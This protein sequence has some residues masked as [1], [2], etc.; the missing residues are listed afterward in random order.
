MPIHRLISS[1][2]TISGI[3][4][5]PTKLAR[6][7]LL[8]ICAVIFFTAVGVRLL[9]WQDNYAELSRGRTDSG[10]QLVAFFYYDQARRIL[11]DGG[12]LFPRNPV[13][14][15]DATVLTHPPGYS[16]LMAAVFKT[17]YERGAEQRLSAADAGLRVIQII[18]DAA[19]TVVTF[20]IAAELFPVAVAIIAAMLCA[21]SPHFAYYSLML[22]PDS[23]SVLPI[24]LAVYFVI[25]ALKRPR[26]ITVITVGALIGLSCWLRSNALLLAPFLALIIQLLFERGKRLRYSLAVMAGAA[27][28]IVPI[29]IRNW[30]VFHQFVPLSVAAG[31]NLVQGIA[32]YDKENSFGMP[33]TDAEAAL[34]DAEWYGRPDYAESLWRPDGIE[35]DKA[36]FGRGL[37]V[38][39]S[40]PGWFLGVMLRRMEFMLRYNDFRQQYLP[41][42]S[43]APTLLAAPN[44][45]HK[46]EPTAQMTAMWSSSSSELMANGDLLSMPAQATILDDNQDLQITGDESRHRDT[47]SYEPIEVKKNADYLL[48]L[49]VYLERGNADLKIGTAN[50]RIV[51]ALVAA[52]SAAREPKRKDTSQPGSTRKP[53]MK[54]LL[55][56]FASGDNTQIRLSLQ[57]STGEQTM[58][59]VGQAEMYEIGPTGYLWTRYPR[60]AIRGVQKNI[61]KTDLMRALIIVGIILLALARQGRALAVLLIVPVYYLLA[62]SPLGT[63]YRYVLAIH[64]FLFVIAAATIYHASLVIGQSTRR[65]YRF[66]R[67]KGARPWN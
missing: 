56:P 35:R 42:L 13:D 40:N 15:G 21:F 49:P 3:D 26:L 34:K 57:K 28:I 2:S 32:D 55:V 53:R 61:F 64:Y 58:L 5:R 22:G 10:L 16:I 30:T 18:G 36:R 33:I 60:A 63:E 50:P 6:T 46:L 24:L 17:F 41:H 14:P 51:L 59:K 11:D 1:L 8:A 52:S 47:F 19:S 37:A 27:V 9:Y 39:R 25:R 54:V 48:R 12:I 66:A 4:T 44:F 43:T 65:G 38:V 62:Q 20:L 23:L 31:L 29:A 7:R 45:G 67:E